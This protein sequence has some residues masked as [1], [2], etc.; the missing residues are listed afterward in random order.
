MDKYLNELFAPPIGLEPVYKTNGITFYSNDKL[1][2][3]FLLAFEKSSKGE[4]IA[5]EVKKLVEKNTIIPCYKSKNLAMFIKHKLSTNTNKLIVAFFEIET[6]KVIILIDNN[7]TIFGS[8]SN[9]EL[10]STTLHECMHLIATTKLSK[11]IQL[12][13]SKLES[14]YREF[15]KNYFELKIDDNKKIN[16][17]IQYISRFEKYGFT[18]VNKNLV[19]LYKLI[20]SLFSTDTNLSKQDF[21]IRLTNLIVAVK[22]FIVSM[23]TLIKNSNKFAMIFTALN[24]AYQKSFGE[25]NNYTM[26]IQE[27]VSVSEVSSVFAEMKPKDPVIKK[28]FQTIS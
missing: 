1:K 10:A 27:I 7:V 22:L 5:N 2:E 18:Y 13:Q 26:P 14:Y 23:T 9:N 3:K 28:L 17:Y 24:Q 11:F 19:S 20:E 21:Q 8:S 15:F 25:K 6:K 16:K 4:N 12:F